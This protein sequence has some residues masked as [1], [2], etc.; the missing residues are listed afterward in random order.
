MFETRPCWGT[1]AFL[2][3]LEAPMLLTA[4]PAER[5]AYIRNIPEVVFEPSV[6]SGWK[7]GFVGVQAQRQV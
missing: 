2:S 1:T 5:L 3:Q 7:R 4:A 6:L